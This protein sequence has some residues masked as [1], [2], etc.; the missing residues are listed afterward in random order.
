MILKPAIPLK[1]A[2][3]LESFK[4]ERRESSIDPPAVGRRTLNFYFCH[5]L[6]C[7]RK[8]EGCEIFVICR[9]ELL[10]RGGGLFGRRRS[11]GGPFAWSRGDFR[12]LRLRGRLLGGRRQRRWIVRK[13]AHIGQKI[14][15]RLVFLHP[16]ISHFGAGGER[17]GVLDEGVQRL[18]T[19][20]FARFGL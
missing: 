13:R 14:G 15:S 3:R 5:N 9:I 19:P 2:A 20:L 17:P 18:G 1:P 4:R 16:G 10:C 8:S 11:I 6:K 12:R 7:R